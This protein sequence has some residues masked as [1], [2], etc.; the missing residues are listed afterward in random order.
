MRL[1]LARRSGRSSAGWSERPAPTRNRSARA[2]ALASA[3]VI[4]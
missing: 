2:E 3:R 4:G 1:G